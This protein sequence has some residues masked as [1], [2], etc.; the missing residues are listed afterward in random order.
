MQIEQ[1]NFHAFLKAIGALVCIV[2]FTAVACAWNI[3][4]EQRKQ[5]R[6][7]E[8]MPLLL[9]VIFS[10]A[11]PLDW[12]IG[13]IIVKLDCLEWLSRIYAR[14]ILLAGLEKALPVSRIYTAQVLWSGICAWMFWWVSNMLVNYLKDPLW[15]KVGLL[16]GLVFGVVCPW[17]FVDGVAD[18]RQATITRSLPF[19]IDLM[20]SAMRGG[21][22]FWQALTYYVEIQ[23][24]GPLEKEFAILQQERGHQLSDE[25]ALRNFAHRVGSI[26]AMSFAGAIIHAHKVGAPLGRTLEMFGAEMRRERFDYAEQKGGR[27][28]TLIL[29]PCFLCI[30]PAICCFLGGAI[31]MRLKGSGF[32]GG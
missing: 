24:L 19:A 1:I 10:I 25:D 5:T 4:H 17:M 18:R 12:C 11:T 20:A 3:M 26:A 15:S 21:M 8:P 9:K 6:V 22:S 2:G 16:L 32:F 13:K 27:I 14:S 7:V 29:F 28:A 23:P 30:L 31:W